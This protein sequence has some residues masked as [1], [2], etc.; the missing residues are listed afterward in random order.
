MPGL[1]FAYLLA[2]VVWLGGLLVLGGVTAPA[3]FDVLQA[4]A[5]VDGRVLAGA[6]FGAVL[7]RFHLVGYTCGGV[8]AAALV[9]MALI[10]PRP[11]PYAPRLAVI[12][13]MLA[14][15]AA[16]AVPIGRQ[17]EAIQAEVAGPIAALPASD[18]RRATFD[19]LH[20]LSNLLLALSVLGGLTLVF[21]EA[22][23]RPA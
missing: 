5:P 20:G 16:T 15:T 11:R 3:L 17:M 1:R 2:L 10:G 12:G 13:A 4:R 6:A 21:W 14:L 8:M 7:A 18:G 9:L 19:R 23:D 22:R